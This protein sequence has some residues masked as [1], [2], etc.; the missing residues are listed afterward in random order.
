[1]PVTIQLMLFY[2]ANLLLD[3]PLQCEF[4]KKYKS[5]YH[6]VMLV[7]CMIWGFGLSLLLYHFGLFAWWKVIFLVVGHFVMDTWKARGWYKGLNEDTPS[8]TFRMPKNGLKDTT[9]YFI[10]QSFH[11]VQL[12][13]VFFL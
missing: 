5:K 3:Y 7:H 12:V 9:A 13:L 11:L 6:T 1:M 10:D 4:Q 2:W 8:S